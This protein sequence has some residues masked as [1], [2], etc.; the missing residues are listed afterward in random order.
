MARRV[1]VDPWFGYGFFF[2]SVT[3]LLLPL[4][5]EIFLGRA[6]LWMIVVPMSTG[7]V[8]LVFVRIFRGDQYHHLARIGD[9]ETLAR[10]SESGNVWTS[11]T[12]FGLTPLHVAAQRRRVD[13]V[14]AALAFKDKE[15][16]KH[17]SDSLGRTPLH[18]AAE[19]CDC[20]IMRLLLS[21]GY[22]PNEPDNRQR[23]PLTI[24]LQ[25]N[26]VAAISV[27]AP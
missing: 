14:R 7:S 13:V 23:T 24:V 16:L 3:P 25:Q 1:V 4:A 27:L 12:L 20:E 26:D 11:R 18:L 22:S 21:I 2:T 10:L 8:F 9:A 6:H 5:S 19:N 17:L 15:S